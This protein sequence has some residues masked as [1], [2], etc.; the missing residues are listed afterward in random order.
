MLIIVNSKLTLFIILHLVHHLT[1][2]Q[3]FYSIFGK[4]NSLNATHWAFKV[5]F[6]QWPRDNAT[7]ARSPPS[8]IM[9]SWARLDDE[10]WLWRKFSWKKKKMKRQKPSQCKCLLPFLT[11]TLS[12]QLQH[13]TKTWLTNMVRAT[14]RYTVNIA[15]AASR[16]EIETPADEKIW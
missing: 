5:C 11:G 3:I 6:N 12:H 9:N 15:N 14:W 7:V 4:Q 8:G 1:D 10:K 16:S 13:K 2:I